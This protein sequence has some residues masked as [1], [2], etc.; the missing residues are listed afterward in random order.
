MALLA[1]YTANK[2]ENE[3]LEE[4]LNTNVFADAKG[5]TLATGQ[6]EVDGFNTYIAQYKQLLAVERKAVELI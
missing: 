3:S 6:A 5:T 4:Y 2:E 1:V